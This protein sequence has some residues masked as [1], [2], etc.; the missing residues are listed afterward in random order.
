MLPAATAPAGL[1][2]HQVD[3]SDA[4]VFPKD[5]LKVHRRGIAAERFQ[6]A[7]QD[8]VEAL[9]ADHEVVTLTKDPLLALK[10]A[11]QLCPLSDLL[12]HFRVEDHE[13]QRGEEVKAIGYFG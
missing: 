12:V 2:Q 13:F 10:D 1:T 5:G 6:V 9:V 11:V 7:P 4:A 8:G 3:Y